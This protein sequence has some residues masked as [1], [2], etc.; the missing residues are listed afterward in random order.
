MVKSHVHVSQSLSLYTLCGV[1]YK[2]CT[3][4]GS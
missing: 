3:F 2:H 4:T 1:Y